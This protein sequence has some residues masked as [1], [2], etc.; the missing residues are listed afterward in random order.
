MPA[1]GVQWIMFS[2]FAVGALGGWF[3]LGLLAIDAMTGKRK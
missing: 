2:F 1:N 3:A